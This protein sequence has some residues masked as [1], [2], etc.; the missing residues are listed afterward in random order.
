M[1]SYKSEILLAIMIGCV[2]ACP[3]AAHAYTHLHCGKNIEVVGA[4]IGWR[5]GNNSFPS[6]SIRRTALHT[7][8]QRWNETPGVFTFSVS[9]WG[10][11]HVGRGNDQNEIWFSTNSGLLGTDPAVCFT[12][13]VCSPFS[14]EI[15]EADIVFNAN[16]PW[17]YSTDRRHLGPYGGLGRPWGT[18]AIHEMGHA[19]GLKHEDDTY[20]V[21]GD[22]RN[23]IHVNSKTVRPYAGEDAANG[24]FH[25]Y[26]NIFYDR[27]DDLSVVHWKHIGHSGEYSSHGPCEVY[28]LDDR[29]VASE[30]FDGW[31]RYKV[32]PGKI[33]RVEFTYENNGY[34]HQAGV[35]VAYYLSTSD[36]IS[37]LDRLIGL[38]EFTMKR[39]KAFT[40]AI[41][42]RIPHDL[43]WGQ[44]YYLGAIV[45]YK[46]SIPEYCETNNATWI[47]I[48][49][50]K[51]ISWP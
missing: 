36:V 11:K 50:V 25:L 8:N 18:T 43:P 17:S 51:E 13:I 38:A 27:K 44:T 31:V 46:G 6:G 34:Y 7:A 19:L 35:K 9:K 33:Y 20:N 49:T 5:A 1:K 37:T 39:N 2:L 40:H 26:P 14:D 28:H 23:H 16:V 15:T 12:Q 45:D 32:E 41:D 42:L 29:P 22:D 4:H 3:Q 30:D 10:D 47:P 48:K 24:A 21:M